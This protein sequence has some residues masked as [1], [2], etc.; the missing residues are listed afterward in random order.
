MVTRIIEHIYF[1]SEWKELNIS[2]HM[3]I[4]FC[5]NRINGIVVVNVMRASVASGN[6]C[7]VLRPLGCTGMCACVCDNGIC[8]SIVAITLMQLLEIVQF[9][10]FICCLKSYE[11][12]RKE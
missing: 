11:G 2:I 10:Q 1:L 9:E 3:F 7:V 8:F 6:N 5:A 4:A 12:E